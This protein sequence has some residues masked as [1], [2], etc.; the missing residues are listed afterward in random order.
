MLVY[1]QRTLYPDWTRHAWRLPAIMIIGVGVAW[2]TTLA[3]LGAFVGRD[4]EFVRTPKFGIGPDGGQWRG[5][6]YRDP[7]RRGSLVEIGLGL[8]CAAATWLFWQYGNYGA[9]PFLGLYTVGFLTVGILTLHHASA[10][11]R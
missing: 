2:S 8:Y 9:V 3:V 11:H 10:R 1:A 6:A 7:R 4:R 5:K